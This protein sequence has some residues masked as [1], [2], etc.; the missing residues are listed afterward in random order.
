MIRLRNLFVMIQAQLWLLPGIMSAGALAL[1]WLILRTRVFE[2]NGVSFW[3]L[4][5][6][7][8]GTARDLLSSLLS[9]MITMTSLV[10]SMTFV[11]LTLAASQLGPRLIRNFMADRQIQAVLG[12]FIGTILY[13]LVVLRSLNDTLGPEG[14]PHVAVTIASVGAIA[15]LFALLFFVHKIARSIISDTVV[16]RVSTELRGVIANTLPLRNGSPETTPAPL[17]P[18]VTW[19]ALRR[20]G[21][22]QTVDYDALIAWAVRHET[23]LTVAVRAGHFVLQEGRHIG[24]HAALPLDQATTEASLSELREA[25]VVGPERSPAQDLE[26]SIRQLV[27][28]ALRALSPGIYDRGRHGDDRAA[29]TPAGTA[30]R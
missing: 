14:I 3:W 29:I 22:V 30:A 12:L 18:V 19:V 24:I 6:G 2:L 16:E 15:C 9:G 17:S 1:A 20:P 4:Y 23:V 26:Y 25:F 28:T 10:V 5:S 13:T 27:E 7:D 21:Y 11:I 8:A